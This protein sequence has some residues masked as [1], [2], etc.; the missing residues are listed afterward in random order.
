[1]IEANKKTPEIVE[2]L[3]EFNAN[4]KLAVGNDV[5]CLVVAGNIRENVI[6]VLADTLNAIKTTVTSKTE[7]FELQPY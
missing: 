7:F 4:R 2:M 1:M 5:M 3:V 6:Q